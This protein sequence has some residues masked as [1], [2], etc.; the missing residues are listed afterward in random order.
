MEALMDTIDI[1]AYEVSFLNSLDISESSKAT[2]SRSLKN[3]LNWLGDREFNQVNMLEYKRQLQSELS[4]YTANLYL[5]T[6]KKFY[7]WLEARGISENIA[8]NIKGISRPSG[9]KKNILTPEVLREALNSIDTTTIEG[10]RDYAIFNLMA[11][12]GLRDVE[13]SRASVEDI[14]QVAGYT[15]L[16]IQGKGKETKD[17]FVLLLPKTLQPINDYLSSRGDKKPLFCSHSDRNRG[18]RLTTRSISRIIKNIFRSIGLNDERLTAHS[19]RHTAISLAI[20]GGASLQQAQ[21]MAR[22]KNINTTLIY[23]HNLQR[24]EDGAERCINF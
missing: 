17:E 1:L 13:V 12:T 7:E 14:K 18:Q 8:K 22:H 16:Y 11:R 6:V 23:F 9:F 15:V 10:K 4:P 5:T 21:A 3:F 19:L 20:A 24:L 2:Y